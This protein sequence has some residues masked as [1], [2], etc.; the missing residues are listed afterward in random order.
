MT[1]APGV[2]GSRSSRA[3]VGVQRVALA[4]VLGACAGVRPVEEASVRPPVIFESKE[5]GT[6]VGEK[7]QP[8]AVTIAVPPAEVWAAAK[9]V[10]ADLDIAVTVENPA[11][12]QIGNPNFYKTRTVG[13]H[14]ME[15]FVNCGSGMTGPKAGSYRIFM[16]L[17]TVVQ[18][19]GKGGT[20]IQTTFVPVGQDM[21][22]SATDR[23]PCGTTGRFE[24]LFLD[25]VK[26]AVGLP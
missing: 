13:R 21:S 18:G 16:S 26:A 10:Y 15:E 22:G 6:L 9:K 12:H 19:D 20:T 4:L 3:R 8:V 1:A 2:R 14:P 5:T 23:I 7:P 25:R 11:A 17:L 24:K